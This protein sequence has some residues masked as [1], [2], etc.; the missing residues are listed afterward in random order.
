MTRTYIYYADCASTDLTWCLLRAYRSTSGALLTVD[1]TSQV[2][3]SSFNTLAMKRDTKR[4]RPLGYL[5][6]SDYSH[7]PEQLS[8]ILSWLHYGLAASHPM[9]IYI[10]I[11]LICGPSNETER[12]RCDD[13]P[14]CGS[15]RG[16]CSWCLA[17]HSIRAFKATPHGVKRMPLLPHV[18]VGS[19]FLLKDHST[20][21]WLKFGFDVFD[22]RFIEITPLKEDGTFL[23]WP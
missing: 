10:F 14:Y 19:A 15:V 6:T 20:S 23:W 11:R 18:S 17:R 21:S 9:R 5:A 13:R 12:E 1:T 2:F 7:G 16:H 22:A 3:A 8:L 4:R